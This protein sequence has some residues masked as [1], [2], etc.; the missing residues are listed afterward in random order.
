MLLTSTLCFYCNTVFVCC[1]LQLKTADV[2]YSDVLMRWFLV[3][4]ERQKECSKLAM[5]EDEKRRRA[6]VDNEM[7]YQVGG[8]WSCLVF[9]ELSSLSVGRGQSSIRSHKDDA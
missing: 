8:V 5:S 3:K 7:Q 9:Y 1:L 2:Q 4:D 6:V